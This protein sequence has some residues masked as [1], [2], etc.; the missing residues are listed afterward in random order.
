MPPT[1]QP[2]PLTTGIVD[3]HHDD[4]A[5]DLGAVARGGVV[6]M[7]H[8]A[9][10]GRDWR[11]PAFP[12]AIGRIADAGLLRAAYHYAT[13]SAPGDAQADF[14]LAVVDEAAHGA[15]DVLLALDLE[16]DLDAPTTM[17]TR[18]AARFV[19]RVREVTGRWPLLYAGASLLGARMRKADDATRATL[20]NC[21][22]WLAAYGPDPLT[23]APPAPWADWSLQQY[24]NGAA[25]PRDRRTFPRKTPGFRRQR[26]DR[27]VFRGT[28]DELRAWWASAGR[29]ID[30]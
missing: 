5:Y 2:A 17:T 4:G 1:P 27:S 21:P 20:G 23:L 11:D 22:L 25:G 9:T 16:G 12:G 15:G 24:T 3:V 6:A 26:Q 10:E 28:S 13:R 7:L 19:A 29:P 14:F 30:G 18:E 8:K